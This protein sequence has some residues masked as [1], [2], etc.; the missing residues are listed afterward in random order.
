MVN[1]SRQIGPRVIDA[2]GEQF[3]QLIGNL[4]RGNEKRAYRLVR[5]EQKEN[6]S[7]S[8][9]VTAQNLIEDMAQTQA[10]RNSLINSP[11]IVPG[12]GTFLSFWLIGAEDFFLLDQSVTLILALCILNGVCLDDKKAVEDFIIQ[13][14]GEAYGIADSDKG[15]AANTISKDF[16][17]KKLPQKY[18]NKG[19]NKGM[20]KLVHR[21]LPIKRRSRL[22]PVGL[23]LAM[24]AYHAYDTIVKVGQLSLKH[25]QRLKQ[26]V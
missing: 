2:L 11:S 20:R 16:L 24:S 22:L 25:M 21:V 12:I 10:L 18:V 4:M 8:I 9:M 14:I 7:L 5:I 1:Q 19:L 3:R 17:T 15:I 6:S 23:G 13:V 26:D